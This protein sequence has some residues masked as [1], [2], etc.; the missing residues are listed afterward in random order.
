MD[1]GFYAACT[2]LVSR[3]EALDTIANN[4]ANA[5][6]VG[7][8]NQ[9]NVF[10]SVLEQAG[11]PGSA[12]NQA[13]NNYGLLSGTTL[14]ETQ[15]ALQKTGNPLDV[16]IQGAGFFVAQTAGG[17]M[18][19]RNGSLQVSSKGQLI[20]ASGDAVMGAKGPITLPPG[21]VSISPDGTI[22]SNGAV[23]GKLKVVQF[24]VGTELTSAGT[25]YY[26][27]PASTAKDATNATVQ[28]GML[29]SSNVNPV[30]SMVE[31]INA[32]R[33]AEM[34]QRALTMFNNE[35]DKTATQELPKIG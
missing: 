31:L 20:T 6:T 35:I 7:Y 13:I 21:T 17:E 27:A 19:T 2:G 14:D 30:A 23:A 3:T 22:S 12:V 4:L 24:P 10:S 28:Q 15:G 9:H 25:N 11:P 1:S 18:Y 32:Q 5:S 8:R 29:E 34:M 33:S 16:A 26:T